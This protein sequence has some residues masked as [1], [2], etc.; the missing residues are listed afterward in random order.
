VRVTYNRTPDLPDNQTPADDGFAAA[1]NPTFVWTFSD[2]DR[3]D[4]QNAFQVQLRTPAGTYGDLGSWDSGIVTSAAN[5]YTPST[6]NLALGGYCWHVRVQDNSGAVNSWTAYSSET[7]FTVERT[8]PVSTA[9][10]PGYDAG[11]TIPVSWAASDEAGGSGVA[12]VVLWFKFNAGAWTDS[13]MSQS[14]STGTFSFAPPGDAEGT[15]YF[16]TIATDVA[17]N[18]EA[19]PAGNGDDSTIYDTTAPISLAAPPP[20][21]INAASIAIPWAAD[22]AVSGIAPGG[23]LLRYNYNGGAYADGPTASGAVGTF[24]F[25]ATEDGTYCFYTIATDNAGNVELAPAAATGDGCTVFYP[26]AAYELYL[27]AVVKDY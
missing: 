17:G 20:G 9:T 7:C 23:V 24:N 21:P 11:G 1:F 5:T 4:A 2:P 26:T 6:W 3:D 27:P 8:A 25:T 22:G 19:G 12:T 16:Q 13:G 15:Y 14:G 18:V 10:S